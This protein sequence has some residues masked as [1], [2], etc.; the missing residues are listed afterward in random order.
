MKQR[1]LGAITLYGRIEKNPIF[2]SLYWKNKMNDWL[3]E[4]KKSYIGKKKKKI[5]C[6]YLFISAVFSFLFFLRLFNLVELVLFKN[7]NQ[8]KF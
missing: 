8:R 7:K 6:F 5:T 3:I 1:R 2:L 4:N